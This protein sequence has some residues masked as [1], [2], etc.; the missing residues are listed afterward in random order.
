MPIDL[1]RRT[2]SPPPPRGAPASAAQLAAALAAL[3][4]YDGTGTDTGHAAEAA[5][6]GGDAPYR[7]HLADVIGNLDVLLGMLIGLSGLLDDG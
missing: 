2:V 3:G 7:M 4:M 5:R 6:L 1:P